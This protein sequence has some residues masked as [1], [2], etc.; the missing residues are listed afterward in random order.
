MKKLFLLVMFFSFN[1]IF[2]QNN[3]K[4]SPFSA[5]RLGV[6]GGIN[7]ETSSDIGRAFILEGKTDLFSNLNLKLS[8]GYYKTLKPVNYTVRGNDVVIIDSVTFYIAGSYDVIKKIYDMFPFS[9]GLQYTFKN[10][11]FTPYFTL[12][13]SYNLI[14]TSIER[15]AGYAMNY[16]SYDEIPD[17]FKIKHVENNPNN[18]YGLSLGTGVIYNIS[19]KIGLDLRYF[20]KYDS[21][22]IN[23][24]HV[25]VGIVF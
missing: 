17:E 1:T 25:L 13:V 12:D 20:Y 5:F 4:E 8:L 19:S 21:E 24:H 6:Y 11:T 3:I 2:S 9:L 7:F 16:D 18:S 22:I 23:T 10:Q 14:S 15:T